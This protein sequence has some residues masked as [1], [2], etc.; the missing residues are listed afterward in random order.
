MRRGDLAGALS[1]ASELPARSN[2]VGP[3]GSSPLI[4]MARA[5]SS[6]AGIL[7]GKSL[8]NAFT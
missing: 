3:F 6:R 8:S 2:T 7:E 4:H 1:E 5:K